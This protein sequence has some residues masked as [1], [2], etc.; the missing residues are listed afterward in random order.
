MNWAT[1]IA[2]RT[3]VKTKDS[4]GFGYVAGEYQDSVVIIE[5]KLVSHGLSSLKTKLIITMVANYL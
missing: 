5:G 3:P 4:M 2:N 1:I